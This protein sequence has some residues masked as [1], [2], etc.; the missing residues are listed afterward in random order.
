MHHVYHVKPSTI[1]VDY[2][3]NAAFLNSETCSTVVNPRRHKALSDTRSILLRLP[4]SKR[5]Y[6]DEQILATFVKGFFGGW[7][8]APEGALLSAFHLNLVDFS[9]MCGYLILIDFADRVLGIPKPSSE[10]LIWSQ[11]ALDESILPPL[12]T[13]LFGAFQVVDRFVEDAHAKRAANIAQSSYVDFAFGSDNSSFAGVHRFTV[14]RDNKSGPGDS[15]VISITF[16]SMACNPIQSKPR[17]PG[18]LYTFHKF[19][20]QLLFREGVAKVLSE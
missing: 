1:V 14:H 10:S 11:N 3:N 2:N 18:I 19:Y 6:S 7:V 13:A 15:D 12:H 4:P 8:F 20:A 9:G 16:A 17:I 5:Q